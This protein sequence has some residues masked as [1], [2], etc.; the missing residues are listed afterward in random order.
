[1]NEKWEILI[2]REWR[3][4]DKASEFYRDDGWLYD[5]PGGGVQ[6]G[7]G[8]REWLMRE[9][10]EEMGMSDDDVTIATSPLYMQIVEVDDRY[11][12]DLEKDDF[13]PTLMMY[14]AVKLAHFDFHESSEYTGYEWVTLEAYQKKLIWSHSATLAEIFHGEDFPKEYISWEKN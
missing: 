10:A 8:F 14:Y 3:Y 7:D 1:M 12:G 13:Y 9:I 6:Y 4:S 11:F 5:L 2:L